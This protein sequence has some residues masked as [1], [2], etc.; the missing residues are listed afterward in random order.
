MKFSHVFSLL[1]QEGSTFLFSS[2]NNIAR[3][4]FLD[5]YFRVAL[6]KK[7]EYIFPTF[8]ICP[9]GNLPYEG[10]DKLSLEDLKTIEVGF[11]EKEDFFEFVFGKRLLSI[12][13]LNFEMSLYENGALLFKDREYLSHNFENEF[14]KGSY[15]YISREEDEIILGLG[16]KTGD[17][18]KN[19]RSFRL[20]TS[21]AMGFDARTSDPLYKHVPFYMCKN[22]VG[23][24]GL[25]Y[26]T[27][28]QGA[29]DFGREINNYYSPFKSFRCEETAL[30]YYVFLGSIPEILT[31]F[32]ELKGPDF[33][34]PIWTLRYCGSTMEYT[35]S[36]DA[37]RKLRDFIKKCEDYGIH[38]G[39]FYLSSGYTQIGEKRYVFHWNKEKI[40]DPEGLANYF[41]EH[42]VEF[43]PNIKP[44]LLTDHPLYE[45]LAKKGYF[46]T[47]QDGSP[48]KFPFWSGEGS[49]LDFTNPE[50]AS[51]WSRCVKENLVD[52]GYLNT[53]N[54]N[55]EYDIQDDE[56][57]A[58]GF[59][60]PIK[61]R[62]IR[63]LFSFLMTRASLEAQHED[64]RKVAVSRSAIVGTSR[65]ASTWTGDNRTS[66]EDFRYNHKMAMTMSLS[67]IYNFGQDI[68]GFAGPRPSKEL[69]LRWI[70]YGI[71]TPRFVLHSWNDDSSSNMPWLY[72]EEKETVKRLFHL[73]D[74]L[75][76]YLYQ[77]MYRSC[78]ESTPIIYPLFLEYPDYDI[79][80]DA[81][82]FG[83]DIIA[84]PIFDEGKNETTIDLPPN[85]GDWYYKKKRVKGR[86]TLKCDIHDD[87]IYFIRGGSVI[88]TPTSYEV[89]PLEEGEMKTIF[90]L[91][92]GVSPLGPNNFGLLAIYVNCDRKKIVVSTNTKDPVNIEV[93]DPSDREVIIEN[94]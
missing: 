44:C 74:R 45:E 21:D 20:S 83:D 54:D 29:F 28:S 32:A 46:L 37:E 33:F 52:K 36:I 50:V 42:G 90:L 65:L 16:D 18:N 69:F 75:I 53:W 61:A 58:Y 12:K 3:L 79:E 2:E 51:F 71:F 81:F 6:Y 27:Y 40:P 59:G 64:K 25:Y 49:Y 91:D 34:P 68:G 31:T 43:L 30:V 86:L 35:D 15:H 11:K 85:E 70:Q 4:D 82:F 63:P 94:R 72:P 41:K 55:N 62:L 22:S 93:I 23:S 57:M 73:R 60:H 84:L 56:T 7:G 38:P 39:G 89:Y 48:A 66:F 9:S 10:R 78:L 14:G 67:G 26:D 87:P 80:S 17:I 1:S 92:D 76:P 5:G 47:N 77:E 8:S 24:Y 13:K 88:P 19:K